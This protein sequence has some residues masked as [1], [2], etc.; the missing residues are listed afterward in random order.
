MAAAAASAGIHTCPARRHVRQRRGGAKV[1]APLMR[2]SRTCMA[3][4]GARAD[5][6]GV[7]HRLQRRPRTRSTST[8]SLRPTGGAEIRTLAE[9]RTFAPH[10]GGSHVDYVRHDAERAGRKTLTR[11][12][13]LQTITT[14]RLILSAGAFGS[15]FL[16]HK[17]LPDVSPMLGKRS[18]ATATS[19]DGPRRHGR[20]G[21]TPPTAADR[22][23]PRAV[24]RGRGQGLRWA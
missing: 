15:A 8:T 2:A 22:C 24:Y 3:S 7:Q 14:D 10:D 17:N 23:Q 4:R 19:D 9:V 21:R 18:R 6:R 13:P 16:M 5:H 20:E 1:G 11:A 12:L